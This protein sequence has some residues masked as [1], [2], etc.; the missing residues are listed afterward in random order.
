MPKRPSSRFSKVH[1]IGLAEVWKDRKGNR[2]VR[3]KDS[4]IQ[5]SEIPEPNQLPKTDHRGVNFVTTFKTRVGG[6]T[7][8]VWAKE[9]GSDFDY[10]EL[11]DVFK[12][13]KMFKFL[14]I[15]VQ[16]GNDFVLKNMRRNYSV[17]N[18]KD[19]VEKF[20]NIFPEF[21]IATDI[22]CGFPGETA[23]QFADTL[24]LVKKLKF[25]VVNISRFV[26]RSGTSAARMKGQISSNVLKNRSKDMSLVF[27]NVAFEQ[28]KKWIGWCGEIVIDE[29][30]KDNV[31]FGRNFAYKLVAI[32][33][34]FSLGQK[35]NI[36]I[37][38][39]ASTS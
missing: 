10:R 1:S 21:C 17:D 26:A 30:G 14:H 22:I 2:F 28:N 35:V 33:G 12:S 25:D 27:R 23:V 6:K 7:Q 32:K 29:Q 5:P 37:I 39:C 16:S 38:G 36:K 4:S 13:N 18:V 34:S 3:L 24:S 19:I 15:P 20:R 11:I 9:A 8:K 31:W